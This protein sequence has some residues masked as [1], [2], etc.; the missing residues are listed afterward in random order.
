MGVANLLAGPLSRLEGYSTTV[1]VAGGLFAFVVV[2]VVWN[3]LKQLLFKNKNEPPVVFHI[4]PFIGSTITYGMDPYNF[5]FKQKEKVGVFASR[6][7]IITD[8]I[9]V[10]RYLHLYLARQKDD[11]VS[12]HCG[13]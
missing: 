11:C 2:S 4:F 1:I 5:F 6:S 7:A 3:I 8:R 9:T 13:K 10:R 12:G